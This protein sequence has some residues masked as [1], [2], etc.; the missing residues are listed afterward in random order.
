[1]GLYDGS[2]WNLWEI[3]ADDPPTLSSLDLIAGR[4]YSVWLE[5]T[6][7]GLAL[8]ADNQVPHYEWDGVCVYSSGVLEKRY[9]GL[10]YINMAGEFEDQSQKR[11]IANHYNR[12]WKSLEYV[13]PYPPPPAATEYIEIV[14][15]I[16]NEPDNQVR[17]AFHLH[18]H[19]IT[20]K[21]E[22]VSAQMSVLKETGQSTN[23]YVSGSGS[24][25]LS[26]SG[27]TCSPDIGPIY[28]TPA[29]YR[30]V[31]ANADEWFDGVP[32]TFQGAVK[33]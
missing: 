21:T 22:W 23:V 25:N 19:L 32:P 27:R 20:R 6:S 8:Y 16:S 7:S 9:L 24:V 12:R 33:L 3:D 31:Y 18:F 10:V 26:Y 14:S 11:F 29:R 1:V 5:N 13:S 4:T 2:Q 28:Y 17:F 15:L 30:V